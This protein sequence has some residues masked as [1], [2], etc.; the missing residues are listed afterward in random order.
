MLFKQW[1]EKA[2]MQKILLDTN[3]KLIQIDENINNFLSK[4]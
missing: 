2:L 1:K 4:N 3:R